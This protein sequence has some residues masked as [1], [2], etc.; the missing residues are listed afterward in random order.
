MPASLRLLVID[1]YTRAAREELRAGGAGVAGELYAAMLKRILPSVRCDILYPSDPDATLPTGQ[2]LSGYDGI[3]WTGC[4][5]TVYHDTPE[6]RGQ[7]ELARAGFAVQVPSFGSCWA[8]QIAVVAAGGIV[9][10]NPRGREM[11][12][13]RKIA[14]TA[15]GRGHPMYAGKASVFDAFISH[16]DEITHLPPGAVLLASNAFSRVQ[17]VSVVH[18]GGV[19]WGLQYH[20]EYDLREMARLSWCRI[21]KLV[22]RGFFKDRAAAEAYIR[23]L[24]ALHQDPAR[25]DIAWLLGI[26]DDVMNTD[27]RTLEVRNWIEV[28][29]LPTLAR[30]R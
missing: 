5:L 4:S 16:D 10:A 19:F 29:V 20:P 14:L 2:A 9:S 11:G 30:R 18:Q 12:V 13:A 1:G 7:I 28:L 6:V 3:A 22:K 24:E 15:E 23:L 27:V 21:E 26:D 25:K 8:A 17:A